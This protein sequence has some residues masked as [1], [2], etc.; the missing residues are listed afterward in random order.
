VIAAIG[1]NRDNKTLGFKLMSS[2]LHVVGTEPK[3]PK[4]KPSRRGSAP[5]RAASREVMINSFQRM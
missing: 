3:I 4:W 5:I 2:T 1:S